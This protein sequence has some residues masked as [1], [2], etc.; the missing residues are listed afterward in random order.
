VRFLEAHELLEKIVSIGSVFGHEGELGLF[1]EN[2]LKRR[3]FETARIPIRGGRFNVLGKRGNRGKPLLLFGHMDTVPPY[4]AWIGEPTRMM[5]DGDRLFG[6]GAF[7][8]KAGIA[9]ILCAVEEESDRQVFVAFSVDEENISEG[10]QALIESGCLKGIAAVV[11]TEISTSESCIGEKEITL[12]R[13][14]RCVLELSVP[15]RSSHGAMVDRGINAISEASVLAL[16]IEKFNVRLARHPLLP[17]PT[18]FVNKFTA[19]STSLSIPENAN[20]EIDVHMVPPETPQSVLV[21]MEGFIAS[22]YQDG[23]FAEIDGRRITARLKERETPYLAPYIT[24]GNNPYVEA[25]SMAVSKKIGAAPIFSYGKSVADDNR[26]AL[27]GVPVM[28]IGPMGGGE[29]TH[30]EWVSRKSLENLVWILREFL[31]SC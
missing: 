30:G 1:I 10:S 27:L 17:A 3:G 31:R 21:E 9:A 7:D 11:S 28:S 24:D 14:G 29:H 6:L 13:R 18:L 12:G 16:E 8:M 25:L 5:G 26:L 22:L 4:G 2:E 19:Q 23:K 15:G 20:L